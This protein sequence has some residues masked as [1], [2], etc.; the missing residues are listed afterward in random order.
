ME[1][2]VFIG[3]LVFLALLFIG[4]AL[5]LRSYLKR[6]DVNGVPMYLSLIHI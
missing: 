5:G 6:N 4:I 1:R 3:L 2:L